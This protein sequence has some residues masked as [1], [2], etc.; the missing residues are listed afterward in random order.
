MLNPIKSV[1]PYV[2]WRRSDEH[3]LVGEL[4]RRALQIAVLNVLILHL[5]LLTEVG[6]IN[7][8][9]CLFFIATFSAIIPPPPP[10]PPQCTFL[11]YFLCLLFNRRDYTEM[12]SSLLLW[13]FADDKNVLETRPHFLASPLATLRPTESS[14]ISFI[15][16]IIYLPN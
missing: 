7:V 13:S 1:T 10:P 5:R 6:Y 16:M 4:R 8:C 3:W 2:S 11:L 14:L 9:A 12:I 15:Q